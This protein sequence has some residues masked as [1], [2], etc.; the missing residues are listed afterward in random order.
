MSL[1]EVIS[2]KINFVNLFKKAFIEKRSSGDFLYANRGTI[3][4]ETLR[5]K[6]ILPSRIIIIMKF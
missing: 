1:T 2:D 6:Y 3:N 4:L 5:T